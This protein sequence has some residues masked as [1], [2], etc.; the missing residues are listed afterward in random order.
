[1]GKPLKRQIEIKIEIEEKKIEIKIEIKKEKSKRW[2]KGDNKETR[3]LNNG[4]GGLKTAEN[5]EKNQKA[6]QNTFF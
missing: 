1:M 4:A 3:R 2:K 6:Y 5:G